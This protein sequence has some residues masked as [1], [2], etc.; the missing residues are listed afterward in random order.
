MTHEYEIGL[1]RM[2]VAGT[3]RWQWVV[4]TEGE[5]DVYDINGSLYLSA[6]DAL[7][8]AI[9]WLKSEGIGI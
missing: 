3:A 6:N 9:D 2:D 5:P 1:V 7:S 8:D 4:R